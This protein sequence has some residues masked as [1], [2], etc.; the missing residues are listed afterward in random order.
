MNVAEVFG[1]EEWHRYWM[2]KSPRARRAVEEYVKKCGTPEFET[3]I[4]ICERHRTTQPTLNKHI[5]G[6]MENGLLVKFH[7]RKLRYEKM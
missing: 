3:Q 1:T 4:T 6:L 2:G 5:R 7:P